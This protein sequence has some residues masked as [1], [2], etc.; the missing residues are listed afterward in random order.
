[1][2]ELNVSD[3]HHHNCEERITV[4]CVRMTGGHAPKFMQIVEGSM[5][6]MYS[7]T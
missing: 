6:S 7:K 1:M 3:E 2:G 4:R 5:L